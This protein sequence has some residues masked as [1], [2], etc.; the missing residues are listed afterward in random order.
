MATQLYYEVYSHPEHSYQSLTPT[1]LILYN[2]LPLF[3]LTY[4][5]MPLSIPE[6]WPLMIDLQQLNNDQQ[7]TVVL[8]V[9]KE[10]QERYILPYTSMKG[11]TIGMHP[12]CSQ[13]M[14]FC[15]IPP[16]IRGLWPGSWLLPKK[17]LV[18]GVMSYLF[19]PSESGGMMILSG[20]LLASTLAFPFVV[21]CVLCGS[22]VDKLVHMPV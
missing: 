16:Q 7:T 19:L 21:Q 18:H 20:L 11:I 12:V 4:A 6:H 10:K 2:F 5:L 15:R 3:H 13:P 9:S 8:K 22:E 1:N 14:T 17:Y